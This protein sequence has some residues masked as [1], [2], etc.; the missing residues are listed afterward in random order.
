[1]QAGSIICRQAGQNM[2]AGYKH[3]E[4][5]TADQIATHQQHIKGGR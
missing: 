2:P 4:T 3:K 1:M 5:I